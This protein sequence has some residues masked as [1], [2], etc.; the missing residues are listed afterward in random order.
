PARGIHLGIPGRDRAGQ[1]LSKGGWH[2]HRRSGAHPRGLPGC[3]REPSGGLLFACRKGLFTRS[4]CRYLEIQ[5]K[6]QMRKLLA[7]GLLALM[8]VLAGCASGP[9]FSKSQSSALFTPPAGKTRIFFYRATTLGFAIQ[10]DIALNG[11]V[12]GSAVPMGIF[13]V[14]REPG[15]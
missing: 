3:L 2:F 7:I 8:S 14:D 11:T 1:G 12:V 10:P 9:Q 15:D 13:F 5:L 6:Y 4:R